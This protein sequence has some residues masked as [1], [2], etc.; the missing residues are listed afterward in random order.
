MTGEKRK[1]ITK[2]FKEEQLDKIYSYELDSVLNV[3]LSSFQ[4][5]RHSFYNEVLREGVEHLIEWFSKAM[6][7]SAVFY[8]LGCGQGKLAM[9]LAIQTKMSKIVGVE[10]S[11]ERYERAKEIA[12][13]V[14][15]P[16]TKPSFVN[17][18]YRSLDLSDATIVYLENNGYTIEETQ[19]IFS[20]LPQGC[21]VI[22]QAHGHLTGD[23]FLQLLTA[24]GFSPEENPLVQFWNRNVSYRYL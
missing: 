20:L 23:R 16:F 17:A 3:D 9:H 11:K 24:F 12:K 19:E 22:Y 18:D 6:G 8:D 15:F 2:K 21:L 7:K 10:L 4:E 5:D 13:E 14:E 1:R